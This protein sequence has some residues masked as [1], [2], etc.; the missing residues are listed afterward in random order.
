MTKRYLVSIQKFHPGVGESGS[1][2]WET[3]VDMDMTDETREH[4]E[5]SLK[6][7]WLTYSI[8]EVQKS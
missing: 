2:I 3:F 4:I 1:W 8:G 5:K 7:M 6:M